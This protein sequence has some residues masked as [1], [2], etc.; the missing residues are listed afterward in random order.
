[1]KSKFLF[2]CLAVMMFLSCGRTTDTRIRVHV[3]GI[4]LQSSPVLM[5]K[6]S[7]YQL[8]LDSSNSSEVVLP[9]EFEAAYGALFL[10]RKH[11]LLYVEPGKGFEVSVKMNDYQLEPS[12]SGDGAKKNQ[13]L[14]DKSLITV[15]DFKLNEEEF[16]AALDQEWAKVE[17]RLEEQGFDSQFVDRERKRLRYTVYTALLEYYSGHIYAIGDTKFVP[18]EFYYQK[19]QD[20]FTEDESILDLGIY[21]EYMKKMVSYVAIHNLPKYEDYLYLL[22]QLKY[23]DQHF[24]N[25]AVAEFM[26]DY[27]IYDEVESNGVTHIGELK[28]IYDAKVKSAS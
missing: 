1:M 6:D 5:T 2:L 8:T 17:K 20:V 23:I 18:N 4:Q 12:F 22:E 9:A 28:P 15:S 10:D 14:N 19:L 13:F 7:L 3:D 24:K 26:V 16:A 25:P 21:Q 27:L 11:V